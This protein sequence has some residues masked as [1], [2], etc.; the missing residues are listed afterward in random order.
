M[1]IGRYLSLLCLICMT[2]LANTGS[3]QPM[4][5]DQAF[6]LSADLFGNDTIL[7]TWTIAPHHYLY[8]ERFTFSVTSPKDANVGSIILPAGEPKKDQ[9]FG[10]YQV[11]SQKITIPIPI[12]NVDPKNTVLSLNFQGCSQ[13]GYCYP[14]TLRQIRAN[15]ID[16]TVTITNPESTP[17]TATQAQSYIR[18]LTDHNIVMMILAFLG[19]GLLLSFTP[20]VLPMLPILSGI[21]VG[22]RHE[23][24]TPAR[25]FRLSL[26][27]VLSMA[28]TYAAAGILIGYLGG[29]VQTLFQQSWILIV[30]SALFVILSLSFFGLFQ[31]KLPAHFEGKIADM[32]RGLHGGHYFGVA[33][34]GCFAT[35]IVSPCVTPALVGVLSFIGEKGSP[36]LGGIAL[37]ALGLGMG[38]PLLAVGV[39][40]GK[41]LPKAGAWMNSIRNVF[42]VFFLAIA[43]WMLQRIIPPALTLALWAALLIGCA[44][45]L[46]AFSSTPEHGWGKLWKGFGLVSFIYGTLLLIGTAQGNGDPFRPINWP[47]MQQANAATLRTPFTIVVTNLAQLQNTLQHAAQAQQP[48]LV[49]FYADWCMSCHEMDRT[50]FQDPNV[51]ATLRHFATIRV[52]V[53]ASNADSRELFRY[54]NLVAPPTL[55]FFNANGKQLPALTLVGKVPANELVTQLTQAQ[56]H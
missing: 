33:M 27:Y 26:V 16:R 18:L 4:P 5:V 42:G 19:F 28:L 1:K 2:T 52:N 37:F 43:I 6:A 53:T 36:A 9:V 47:Q 44:V 55:L 15:F 11:Y 49:D 23:H 13:D 39:A 8:R 50:T 34:M 21:I 56:T 54:F 31:L 10:S 25:S 40:G 3:Q 30:F 35:L 32:S 17:T 7:A 45:Y 24:I 38:L 12:I 20:C 29:S 22:Q 14:P 46:G 51:L 48:A 41:I